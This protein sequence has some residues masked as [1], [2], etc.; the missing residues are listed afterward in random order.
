MAPINLQDIREWG[1]NNGFDVEDGKPLPKG[2]RSAFM[3]RDDK[4]IVTAISL[5]DKPETVDPDDDEPGHPTPEKLAERAPKPYK[6]TVVER[7]RKLADRARQSAP[8]KATAAATRIRSRVSVD[9]IIERAWD[10]LGRVIQPVNLPVARVMAIQAPVAGML[11]EDVIKNTI[12]DRAL[13]PIARA[14]ERGELAFALIGP[15]LL[16][17][18]LTTEKGQAAAPILVPMLKE[19]LRVW[20]TVAGPKIEIAQKREA[21]FAEKYGAQIDDLI[22]TFFA[23]PDGSNVPAE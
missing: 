10:M 5:K 12:V 3:A 2:L 22:A 18:A 9:R 14:E 13:Q 16:V 6:P 1:K 7:A 19:S 4:E 23:P 8:K 21:E 20:L 17:G 11:L 15:P